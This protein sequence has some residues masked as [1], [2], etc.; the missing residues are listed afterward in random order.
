MHT[1]LAEI[2]LVVFTTLAPSGAMACALMALPGILGRGD[3]RA[4]ARLDRFLCLPLVVTMVGLVASA[5]HLGNPSN[6]LYAFTGVGR[7]PLSTEVTA[8]VAFLAL[9]GLY[10]LY[11]FARQPRR[12]LQRAWLVAVVA[13]ALVFIQTVARA[14]AVQT[15]PTWNSPLVPVSLWLNALVGGPLLAVATTCWARC[16]HVLGVGRPGGRG[17]G[18]AALLATSACALAANVVVA[19]LQARELAGISNALGPATRLVP[20]FPLMII[21]FA[22][23]AA[24]GIACEARAL[25]RL[26]RVPKPESA[27]ETP[28]PRATDALLLAGTLAVFAGILLLRLAFYMSHMTAG[29]GA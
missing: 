6:A 18:G 29:F 17:A 22:L 2:T 16:E 23:L 14:Y 11:S 15:I 27:Q 4:L 12:G 21:G 1:A 3:A 19:S 9:A 5:T 10:W 20:A 28:A 13:S 24:V 8:A 7:S 26:A 25:R